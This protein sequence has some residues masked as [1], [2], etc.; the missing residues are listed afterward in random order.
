[1][2]KLLTV[3][4]CALLTC[5]VAAAA[6]VCTPVVDVA[7][8][9]AAGCTFNGYLFS[10][11]AYALA[12]GSGTPEVDLTGIG[13]IGNEIVLSFNP[14]EGSGVTDIHLQFEV[15]G[16]LILGSDLALSAGDSLA[17][18]SES[19]CSQ[20]PSND[21]ALSG[22]VCGTNFLS[23]NL[24]VF[25]P[26][27]QANR[28]SDIQ[29]YAG[30]PQS[31]VWVWKDIL[32]SQDGH[33]TAFTESFIVPEPMTLSLMGAGLLGIGLLGRRLRKK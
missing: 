11:W 28:L 6:P 24:N 4:V 21:L 29:T 20:N 19:N 2:K 33:N 16:G 12:A 9:G 23:P 30:G 26:D 18:I 15:S 3:L 32:I 13:L 14:N 27:L 31:D 10:N 7:T 22:T 5:L 25:T 17:S 1:M 8:L